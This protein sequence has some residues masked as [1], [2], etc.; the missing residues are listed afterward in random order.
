MEPPLEAA[1]IVIGM[2][3]PFCPTPLRLKWSSNFDPGHHRLFEMNSLQYFPVCIYINGKFFNK[4]MPQTKKS[5]SAHPK[6]SFDSVI[7]AA[8]QLLALC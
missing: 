8:L 1:S 3:H 4:P 6:S 7:V 5:I 2:E